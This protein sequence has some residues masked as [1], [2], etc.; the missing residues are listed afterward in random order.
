MND[1]I[2][3]SSFRW[4]WGWKYPKNTFLIHHI[5]PPKTSKPAKSGSLFY[6]YKHT[7]AIQL[8]AIVDASYKFLY[9]DVGC[10]GRIGVAGVYHN[11][12]MC[13][14]LVNIANK[15]PKNEPL[16]LTDN[17]MPYVFVTDEAF[18]VKT[19]IMSC[20]RCVLNTTMLT[21]IVVQN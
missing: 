17:A 1:V 5:E 2:L 3:T 14:A 15:L 9:V 4:G 6:T 18:S 16:P 20:R 7:F 8:L 11:S 19:Y 12:S 10:Q 13:H 21:T